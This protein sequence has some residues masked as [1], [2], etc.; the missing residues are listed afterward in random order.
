MLGVVGVLVWCVCWV[1]VCAA[2]DGDNEVSPL[3]NLG[4]LHPGEL[5]C[6]GHIK[7]GNYDFINIIMPSQGV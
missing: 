6:A 5:G 2:N 1:R 4:P 7:F 3:D